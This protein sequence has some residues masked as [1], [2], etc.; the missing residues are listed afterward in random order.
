MDVETEEAPI[1]QPAM[2]SSPSRILVVNHHLADRAGSELAT[3]ELAT[4][5]RRQGCTVAVFTLRAGE[6]A[7]WARESLGLDVYS[8]SDVDKIR[9]FAPQFVIAHHWPTLLWLEQVAQLDSPWLLGFLGKIPALENPPP[10]LSA[11]NSPR[12]YCISEGVA[13]EV[14]KIRGWETNGFIMRNWYDDSLKGYARRSAPAQELSQVAIVSNHLSPALA[15]LMSRHEEVEWTHFGLPANSRLVDPETLSRFDAVITIGRT[16]LLALASGV[17]VYCSDIHGTDGWVTP[18][19]VE[20]FAQHSF[21]GRT[22]NAQLSWDDIR[23]ELQEFPTFEELIWLQRWAEEQGRLS[24][25]VR[26]LLDESANA[27]NVRLSDML[28][29]WSWHVPDLYQALGSVE[30]ALPA[31]VAERDWWFGEFHRLRAR[32]SVRVVLA[33]AGRFGRTKLLRRRGPG[34]IKP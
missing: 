32:R 22:R 23:R 34:A 24:S 31:L 3:L 12:H 18:Q 19:T 25:R 28:G 16:V 5:L 8:L 27:N 1:S 6:L 10:L 26:L 11:A 9:N 20:S 7:V 29:R 2:P 33:L 13:Q 14:R 15:E 4:E 30:Q 21:S 17:P